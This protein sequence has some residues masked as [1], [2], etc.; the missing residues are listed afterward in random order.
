MSFFPNNHV[1][2]EIHP[3]FSLQSKTVFSI[4]PCWLLSEKNNKAEND[5][6]PSKWLSFTNP[7]V[8]IRVD[9]PVVSFT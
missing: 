3:A 1:T 7:K 6:V 5:I 9:V 8:D 2:Y 4:C